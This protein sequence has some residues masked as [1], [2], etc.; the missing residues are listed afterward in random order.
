[1]RKSPQPQFRSTVGSILAAIM[2]GS[3]AFMVSSISVV[4]PL[5]ASSHVIDIAP[6]W[7]NV[8]P[9]V[10]EGTGM[11]GQTRQLYVER[12]ESDEVVEYIPV[13]F[14]FHRDGTYTRQHDTSRP[15]LS[16]DEASR[17]GEVRGLPARWILQRTG[18]QVAA[19]PRAV[20]VGIAILGTHIATQRFPGSPGFTGYRGGDSGGDSGDGGG[21]GD[22]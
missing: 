22:H 8:I 4:T 2:L 17:Y 13:T 9:R 18:R 12:I 14:T 15:R 3:G 5:Q 19:D 16:S 1:M 11:G 7:R 20:G 6:G 10:V 21:G